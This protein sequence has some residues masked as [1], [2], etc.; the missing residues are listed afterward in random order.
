MPDHRAVGERVGERDPQLDEV[1]AGVRVGQ[2]DRLR[3]R[4]V[5]EAAREW[6]IPSLRLRVFETS[7]TAAGQALA[8]G[9]LDR[10]A[11]LVLVGYTPEA[12]S[13]IAGDPLC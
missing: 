2:T 1:G 12:V 13:D 6:E 8:F 4:E 9:L 11:T 7:G 10:A 5:R 3:R